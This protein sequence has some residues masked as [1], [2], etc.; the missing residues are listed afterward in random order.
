MMKMVLAIGGSILIGI[1]IAY[2]IAQL[3]SIVQE[4]SLSEHVEEEIRRF[5]FAAFDCQC[6]HEELPRSEHFVRLNV[7]D[8]PE[9][10]VVIYGNYLDF[11]YTEKAPPDTFIGE[12]FA[13]LH[14][15]HII[16][17]SPGRL[18]CVKYNS[19]DSAALAEAIHAL[20]NRLYGLN[21][22]KIVGSLE[23]WGRA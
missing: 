9:A 14:P 12:V 1:S 2:A 16:D 18:A 3:Q 15:A 10:W 8:H 6:L 23:T 20:F 11:S 5:L 22:F 21:N 13:S 4:V 17:W 7:V 19:A